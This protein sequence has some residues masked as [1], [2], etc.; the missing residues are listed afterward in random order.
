MFSN[1]PTRDAVA[2][3]CHVTDAIMSSI[4]TGIS[5]GFSF[6]FVVRKPSRLQ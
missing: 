4:F 6:L 3:S 1:F 5:V 2:T